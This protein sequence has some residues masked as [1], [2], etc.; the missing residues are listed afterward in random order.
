MSSEKQSII[1]IVA[2]KKIFQRHAV[3]RQT[4]RT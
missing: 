1:I 4:A 2:L 3:E